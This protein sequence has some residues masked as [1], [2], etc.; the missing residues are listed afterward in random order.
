MLLILAAIGTIGVYGYKKSFG[1]LGKAEF[2]G[3]GILMTYLIILF[4]AP[5]GPGISSV[6]IGRMYELVPAICF[7]YIFFPE[8]NKKLP[9]LYTQIASCGGIIAIGVIL[10]IFKVYVW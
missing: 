4:F 9:A 3:I 7:V 6:R 10:V 5:G 8:L 1:G 2:Y